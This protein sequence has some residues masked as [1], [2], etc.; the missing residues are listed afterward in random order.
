MNGNRDLRVRV[1]G[2][3]VRVFDSD[4][5]RVEAA[6]D[7][8]LANMEPVALHAHLKRKRQGLM[9]TFMICPSWASV[10]LPT[11]A[12]L[13]LRIEIAGRMRFD[14]RNTINPH[15]EERDDSR[16]I[17]RHNDRVETRLSLRAQRARV[18]GSDGARRACDLPPLQE[19]A[20]ELA[21]A[22][23]RGDIY[24]GCSSAANG[25]C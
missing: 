1:E 24:C 14:E 2:T 20:L 5:R 10:L 16:T 25:P 4:G 18:E 12:R 21:E 19:P 11:L 15:M 23:G 3:P 17:Y 6:I 22:D 13:A 9:Q 8:V 7:R